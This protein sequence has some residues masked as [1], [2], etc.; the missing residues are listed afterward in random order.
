M[1][2]LQKNLPKW[3]FLGVPAHPPYCQCINYI[4]GWDVLIYW[5][6][7][8]GWAAA[9]HFLSLRTS[10][11]FQQAGLLAANPTHL[12]DSFSALIG[13]GWL[14]Y[15]TLN[16]PFLCNWQGQTVNLVVVVCSLW[17][18]QDGIGSLGL[19]SVTAGL[20]CWGSCEGE[21]RGFS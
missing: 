9:L 6:C 21:G 2:G 4:S 19:D 11:Q 16:W 14:M 20:K 1:R 7:S 5:L 12:S 18:L 3:N 8:C 13:V 15:Q 17:F 10:L